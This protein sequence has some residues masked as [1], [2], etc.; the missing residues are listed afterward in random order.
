MVTTRSG[1]NIIPIPKSGKTLKKSSRTKSLKHFLGR[2]KNQRVSEIEKSAESYD[3]MS[4]DDLPLS[5]L[6]RKLKE[7]KDLQ[8]VDDEI[9]KVIEKLR[10]KD[11]TKSKVCMKKKDYLNPKIYKKLSKSKNKYLLPLTKPQLEFLRSKKPKQGSQT[12][13]DVII[14]KKLA[15]VVLDKLYRPRDSK[16]L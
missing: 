6:K 8:F 14:M 12:R 11:T 7:Q 9:N 5:E 1:T 16:M 10:K 3:S 2:K 15:G 13:S 4:D